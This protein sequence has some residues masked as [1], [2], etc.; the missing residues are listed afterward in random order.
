[1]QTRLYV[2]LVAA[3]SMSCTTMIRVPDTAQLRPVRVKDSLPIGLNPPVFDLEEGTVVGGH[4][5]NPNRVYHLVHVWK[6][7]FEV[8]RMEFNYPLR[9]ELTSHGYRFAVGSRAALQLSAR[10]VGMTYN[11]F[12]N[13]PRVGWTEAGVT[14][15]WTLSGQAN[16]TVT[17]QGASGMVR[18]H[19]LAS[20]FNAF[21][22]ALR[23]FLADKRVAVL[24]A[25]QGLKPQ[26]VQ[27]VRT[28]PPPVQPVVVQPPVQPAPQPPVQPTPPPVQPTPPPVQPTP[29]PVQPAP[30]PPTGIRALPRPAA[31]AAPMADGTIAAQVRDGVV[32][33]L[34][35]DG[36]SSG[37]VL[38]AAGLV[39]TSAAGVG[40]ADRV[41]VVTS[42]G[43]EHAATVVTINPAADLALL[44][45]PG[46]GL[47][48]L[49]FRLDRAGA[50]EKIVAIGTPFHPA[51]SFSVS[52]GKVV[53]VRSTRLLTDV[54]VSSGNGGGPVVDTHGRVVGIVTWSLAGVPSAKAKAMM[55][56]EA[57]RV[58][59]L[60]YAD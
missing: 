32:T 46:G 43:K 57:F 13:D 16:L 35:G 50:A 12:G 3:L 22:S 1:M 23:N 31:A 34:A 29:P 17:T 60:A 24:L 51:L 45:V 8:D 2:V 49:R 42:D 47:T 28:P 33:V 6:E 14:V 40:K 41:N 38:S 10:I 20:L 52:R 53:G 44:Q 56:G 7:T 9:D 37:I 30:A 5:A 15:E 26:P 27:I 39:V 19:S 4:A 48:P 21:R 11:L 55:A 54:R 36:W 58:L 18:P 59:G 25:P